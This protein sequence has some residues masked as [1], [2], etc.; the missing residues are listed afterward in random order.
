M[1]KENI[2]QAGI[3]VFP[4]PVVENVV[5]LKISS[6][7]RNT[8]S[9]RIIDLNGKIL[10]EQVRPVID[11]NNSLAVDLP[12]LKSGVYTMQV[13]TREKTMNAK[14]AVLK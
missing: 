9:I 4:N 3:S 14:F 13:I 6:S 7:S 2:Q 10:S 8:I 1:R 5:Q 12:L 11:G